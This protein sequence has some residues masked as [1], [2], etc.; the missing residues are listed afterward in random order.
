MVGERKAS[1]GLTLPTLKGPLT[2]DAWLSL[3]KD[4]R[5]DTIGKANSKRTI[6]V[7]QKPKFKD[8]DL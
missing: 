6:R 4:W 8:S 5:L 3:V 2:L 1:T 7:T